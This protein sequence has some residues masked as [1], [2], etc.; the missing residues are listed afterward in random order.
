MTRAR[1][2]VFL[3]VDGTYALHGAVPPAHE[4][5]VR[6]ARANGHAVF[7]CT[8]RPVSLLNPTL[9]AAG[10]DGIVAG[11]GAHVTVAGEVIADVRIPADLT[12]GALAALDAAGTKY[13]VEAPE[14]T[15]A[16]PDA[17]ALLA[18]RAAD[19]HREGLAHLATLVDIAAAIVARED[20]SGVAPTK[21]TAFDG[22]TLLTDIAATLNASH[23]EKLAVFPSS[24]AA[25]GPGSGE[26]YLARI[27]KAVGLE[28]AAAHRGIAREDT[29]AMGDHLNDL[30][31]IEYAGVGVAM[32]DGHPDVIAVADMVVPGPSE[33][34][35]AVAFERLGLT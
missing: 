22:E 4:R 10:F 18:G 13:I 31:M 24:I 15:F 30:E 12:A 5:S 35:V 29:I 28:A 25:L 6:E 16:H 23:E 32:A 26:L 17:I 1:K 3:D 9:L 20:L 14:G 21:I 34:G 11:A 33:D 7:L 19:S 2:A 8:G 27:T